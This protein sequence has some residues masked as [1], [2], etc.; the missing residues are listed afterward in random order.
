MPSRYENSYSGFSNDTLAFSDWSR[1]DVH[2]W[3]GYLMQKNENN[4]WETTS[5]S[6]VLPICGFF[7]DPSKT[8]FY[9]QD[10]ALNVKLKM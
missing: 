1:Y 10:S 7:P 8:K 2:C 9:S 5:V 4:I 3:N 6:A